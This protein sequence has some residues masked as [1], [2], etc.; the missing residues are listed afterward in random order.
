M[1]LCFCV[2]GTHN[3]F[4]V[5]Q[6]PIPEQVLAEINA[7]AQRL[8]RG[9]ITRELEVFGELQR[10]LED[11]DLEESVSANTSIDQT[12]MRDALKWHYT[13]L[14]DGNRTHDFIYECLPVGL[15]TRSHY[16]HLLQ[17]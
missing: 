6:T 16:A 14:D 2:I 1:M 12:P 17:V 9:D 13:Y 4:C 7:S 5:L 8:F 10:I 15:L 3:T 11:K